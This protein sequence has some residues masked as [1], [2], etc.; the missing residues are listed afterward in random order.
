MKNAL[1]SFW[2]CAAV[3]V[4]GVL[5]PSKMFRPGSSVRVGRSNRN[6]FVIPMF[7]RSVHVVLSSGTRVQLRTGDELRMSSAEVPLVLAS[8]DTNGPWV[9]V[10]ADR[11][12]IT[13]GPEVSLFVRY[14]P[15]RR[16]MM[17]F[18]RLQRANA[19][20]VR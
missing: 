15:S 7:D 14:F 3:A 20:P 18:V 5:R 19:A 6:D 10:V 16:Q 8:R 2:F 13:L 12:N 9:P 11:L 4:D 1:R 17:E